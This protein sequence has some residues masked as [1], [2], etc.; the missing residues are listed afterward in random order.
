[1]SGRAAP[2]T[3][4][5]LLLALG[6]FS[7]Q[8][9]GC[10]F[11]FKSENFPRSKT[12]LHLKSVILALISSPGCGIGSMSPFSNWTYSVT[13]FFKGYWW[14]FLCGKGLAVDS[15]LE[16]FWLRCKSIFTSNHKQ[17]EENPSNNLPLSPFIHK[18]VQSITIW[19]V[20]AF[21]WHATQREKGILHFFGER[22]TCFSKFEK[23]VSI[24]IWPLALFWGSGNTIVK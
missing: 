4:V 6:S 19:N 12:Q 24:E 9:N 23:G 8:V 21:I 16:L 10:L 17:Q 13:C 5:P 18:S 7:Q 2:K 20:K 22:V 3:H 1:M 11:T 15:R 14:I